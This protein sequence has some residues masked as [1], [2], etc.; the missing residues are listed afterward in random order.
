M[1]PP[2]LD[3]LQAAIVDLDGTLVDTL[4]DFTV[5]LNATLS[6]LDLPALPPEAIGRMVG[7]GSE[8][9]PAFVVL[10]YM[11]AAA[12]TAPVVLVGKGITFD[13]GGISIKPA[14]E[15]DEM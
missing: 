10:E 7:K 1:S 11:G 6:E 8:H 12:A 13:T 15:M 2:P 14:A 5:A 4:G 3:T 9:P